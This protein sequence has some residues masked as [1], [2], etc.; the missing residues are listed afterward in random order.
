MSCQSPCKTVGWVGAVIKVQSTQKQ[1]RASG[2]S[3]LLCLR[4]YHKKTQK[5]GVCCLWSP[6]VLSGNSQA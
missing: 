3:S 6:P 5:G 2:S 4:A 1:S